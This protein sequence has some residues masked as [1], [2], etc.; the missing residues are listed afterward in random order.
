MT[1]RRLTLGFVPLTDAAPLL[2][3]QARGFFAAEGLE[4]TLSREVS[5]ATIRDKVAVGALDGA[6]MLA[7]LAIAATLSAT[8]SGVS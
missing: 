1:R 3:A 6:H 5:W 2:V 7:P 4:V 8:T